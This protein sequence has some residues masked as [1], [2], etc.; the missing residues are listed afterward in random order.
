MK[1]MR[2]EFDDDFI[3]KVLYSHY[4]PIWDVLPR[5]LHRHKFKYSHGNDGSVHWSIHG[6]PPKG[7]AIYIIELQL[8]SFYDVKGKRFSVY[9][10][11]NF[12]EGD[13]DG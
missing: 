5:D 13:N 2:I 1:P 10:N 4:S 3:Y 9:E 8:L 6:S 12:I 7:Y 11:I